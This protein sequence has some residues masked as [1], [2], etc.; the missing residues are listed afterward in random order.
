VADVDLS[1]ASCT[2]SF[3]CPLPLA[4]HDEDADCLAVAIAPPQCEH[5]TDTITCRACA[6]DPPN[7]WVLA[8]CDRGHPVIWMRDDQWSYPAP[9]MYCCYDDLAGAHAGCEHAQHGRWRSWKVARWVAGQLYALGV[10]SGS[11]YSY[12]A[13]CRGCVTSINFRGSRP[14]VLGWPT[15]KWACVLKFRHWP[16]DY[17]GFDLCAKSLPCPTCDSKTAGHREDCAE[18]APWSS[19]E[20]RAEAPAR[21]GGTTEDGA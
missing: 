9:C 7:G 17:V 4:E 16:G 13:G 3:D 18:I 6:A 8:D 10:I 5:G 19:A 2:D 20:A 1:T 15:W 14:Y 21:P 11:C 12:G